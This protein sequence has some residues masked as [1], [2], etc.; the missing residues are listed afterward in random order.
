[1]DI[2]M[3]K[4]KDKNKN[5]DKDKDKNKDKNKLWKPDDTA[6]IMNR[7]VLQKNCSKR[8]QCSICLEIIYQRLCSYLPCKHYFHYKC[9]GQLI[10]TRSYTCPLCRHN[11]SDSLCA[12]GIKTL[13]SHDEN[14]LV[15]DEYFLDIAENNTE[16]FSLTIFSQLDL[17]DFIFELLWRSYEDTLNN[18]NF[19][20]MDY[21]YHDSDNNVFEE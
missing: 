21:L 7:I 5:K 2:N 19:I 13:A 20:E 15:F 18:D 12:L 6:K 8:D 17:Y 9:L 11:F 14:H 16:D 10:D 3:D 1:M 4:D